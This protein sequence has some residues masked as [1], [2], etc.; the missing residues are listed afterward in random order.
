MYDPPLYP[1]CQA[2]TDYCNSLDVDIS[3][4][5][6]HFTLNE[7]QI[8]TTLVSTSNVGRLSSNIDVR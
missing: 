3:K 1:A 4:L 8:A 6:M 5:A 2:A 7:E